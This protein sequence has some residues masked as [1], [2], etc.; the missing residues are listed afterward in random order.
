[1]SWDNII[2]AK[3]KK[4]SRD[5]SP[6]K[7]TPTP[8]RFSATPS[9]SPQGLH[10]TKFYMFMKRWLADTHTDKFLEFYIPYPELEGRERRSVKFALEDL[11]AVGRFGNQTPFPGIKVISLTDDE[12]ELEFDDQKHL[13]D[14]DKHIENTREV[15]NTY[16]WLKSAPHDSEIQDAWHRLTST[17]KKSKN[18]RRVMASKYGDNYWD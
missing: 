9:P 18:W 1:M 7:N 15:K 2:K 3:K 10:V 4:P 11:L 16:W 8:S 13:D 17:I 6:K 5:V 12:M 14:R